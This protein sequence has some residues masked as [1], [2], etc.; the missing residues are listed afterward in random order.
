MTDLKR[1][2]VELEVTRVVTVTVEAADGLAARE[3]AN[4]LEYD[5]EV[6]SEVIRWVVKRV[7]EAPT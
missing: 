1:F 4:N 7:V 2:N 3:R 5:L 6:E